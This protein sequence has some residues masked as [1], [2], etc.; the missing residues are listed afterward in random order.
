MKSEVY[1]WRVSPGL[2]Q[3]LEQ[4][5]RR[6][7]ESVADLLDQIA[8]QWLEEHGT[9]DDQEEQARVRRAALRFIGRVAG[10]DPSRSRRAKERVKARLRRRRAG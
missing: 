7:G 6:R 3:E 4:E 2:K 1:S 8:A 9:V 5:A 10:G